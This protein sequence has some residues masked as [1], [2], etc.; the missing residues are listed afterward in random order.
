M[1]TKRRPLRIVSAS[2]LA[3]AGGGRAERGEVA[4][5]ARRAQARQHGRLLRLGRRGLAREPQRA[6]RLPRREHQ[7]EHRAY[8][9][10]RRA[11]RGPDQREH[12][13]AERIGGSHCSVQNTAV[14]HTPLPTAPGAAPLAFRPRETHVLSTTIGT[15]AIATTTGPD[16]AEPHAPRDPLVSSSYRYSINKTFHF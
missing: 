9:A 13:P 12:F 8:R 10:E 16:R 7:R 4:G 2:G 11:R 3:R 15:R 5:R 14:S 1:I 6:R